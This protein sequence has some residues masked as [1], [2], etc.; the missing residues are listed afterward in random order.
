MQDFGIKRKLEISKVYYRTLKFTWVRCHHSAGWGLTERMWKSTTALGSLW[1]M[2]PT[3]VNSFEIAVTAVENSVTF[4]GR[5]QRWIMGRLISE[6]LCASERPSSVQLPKMKRSEWDKRR[7]AHS[8]SVHGLICILTMDGKEEEEE[9]V[10]FIRGF[11]LWAFWCSWHDLCFSFF[12][13]CCRCGVTVL[14]CCCY[15]PT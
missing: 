13:L 3:T 10:R 5:F 8:V 11:E 15:S 4:M 2:S 1:F 12:S 14:P 7:R 6:G 9:G